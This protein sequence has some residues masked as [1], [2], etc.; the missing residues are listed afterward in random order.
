MLDRT[1]STPVA[2][3]KKRWAL[4]LF[5]LLIVLLLAI[6]VTVQ[7]VLSSTYPKTLVVGQVERALGLNVEAQSLHTGWFGHTVLRDVTISLP[8]AD[9]AFLKVP[10]LRVEH[11]SLPM[12][13]LR[14]GV[15]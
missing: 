13:V 11:S 9:K 6:V 12:N 14:R 2:K 5:L 7:I 15:K 8:L 4:R 10:E 3:K 1:T